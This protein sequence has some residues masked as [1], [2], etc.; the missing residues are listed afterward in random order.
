M[1]QIY[2]NF[3]FPK[4]LGV[5]SMRKQCVLSMSKQCVLDCFSQPTHKSSEMNEAHEVIVSTMVS[6]TICLSDMAHE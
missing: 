6:R 3:Q 1:E 2:R 4:N 5:L